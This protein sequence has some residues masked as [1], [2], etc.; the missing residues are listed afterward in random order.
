MDRLS[1]PK[2]PLP[3]QDSYENVDNYMS[4]LLSFVTTSD[5]F[6]TLCGGLH[7]LDFFVSTPD[8][9]TKT[10]E[11]SWREW[12]AEHSVE[13]LLDYFLRE[14]AAF[15]GSEEEQYGRDPGS[16]WRGKHL[17]PASLNQYVSSIQQ[18]ALR[19][20]FVPKSKVGPMSK[21]VSVGMR[22]KKVHEID[23]FSRYVHNLVKETSAKMKEKDRQSCMTHLVDFGSGLNYLGRALASHP[24]NHQ[25]IAVESKAHNVKKARNMDISAGVEPK[26]GSRR[27][28]KAYRAETVEKEDKPD[29]HR[30]PT[31]GGEK[32]EGLQCAPVHHM[33]EGAGSI[34]HVE[35]KLGNGDLS[36]ILEACCNQ[37]GSSSAFYSTFG[38]IDTP[39]DVANLRGLPAYQISKQ[40]VI[41]LHSCGNLSHHAIRSLVAN[42]S[43][44][45]IAIVGCCYNLVTER[46][47]APTYKIPGLRPEKDQAALEKVGDPHGFPMSK[48][49]CEY[50]S[51]DNMSRWN[52]PNTL[53][54][55]SS[56]RG[57]H[58]NITAR[59]MAVQAPENW[60]SKSSAEFFKRHFFRALLQRVF[61]DHGIAEP[62]PPV[63]IHIDESDPGCVKDGSSAAGTSSPQA[64]IIGSL[65]KAAYENFTSYVRAAISRLTQDEHHARYNPRLS[66]R[67]QDRLIKVQQTLTNDDLKA[68]EDAFAS[69]RKDLEIVWS[70]MAVSAQL[71]E[72]VIIADRWQW[73]REQEVVKDCWVEPVFDYKE[74]PRNLVIVG[75]KR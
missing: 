33:K 27:N 8:L 51:F 22:E 49:V 53:A 62:P 20:H 15:L 30:R 61:V 44:A 68:Y 9:Y 50:R 56:R 18:L 23:H 11:A 52:P 57:V 35:K 46:L 17:P 60:D 55:E 45:A 39:E 75:I 74:S 12:F 5:V 58:F 3:F 63:H 37:W 28:K 73:L 4:D 41:S 26:S 34:R 48:K 40:M 59:M 19:R 54:G 36:D 2:H 64:I 42:D 29:L 10:I 72:A 32:V 71:V 66:Q 67:Q 14:D 69:R 13:T 31:K 47:S 38:S 43:V 24:F 6:N 1:R 25:I 16:K 7:I 21:R 65:K 70:L